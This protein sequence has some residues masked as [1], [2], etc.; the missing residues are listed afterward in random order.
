MEQKRR[1]ELA[2]FRITPPSGPISP[3]PG[4]GGHWVGNYGSNRYD[5][6]PQGSYSVGDLWHVVDA[7]LDYGSSVTDCGQCGGQNECFQL[8]PWFDCPRC[9]GGY[10]KTISVGLCWTGGSVFV[11]CCTSTCCINNCNSCHVANW[12]T[13]YRVYKYEFLQWTLVTTYTVPGRIWS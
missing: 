11:P 8:G 4:A 3:I 9:P 1:S 6:Y 12:F 7:H 5:V 13:R 2:P 10:S